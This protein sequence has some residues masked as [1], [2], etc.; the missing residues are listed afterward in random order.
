MPPHPLSEVRSKA[1]VIAGPGSQTFDRRPALTPYIA[2]IIAEW[3][4]NEAN[5]CTLLTY[6]LSAEA[7]PVMTMMQALRSSSAQFDMIEAAASNKLYDPELEA[8]E[9]VMSYENCAAR[10]VQKK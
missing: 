10:G 9:A 2:K 8:F 3:S 5:S 4:Y 1:R 6:F 7:G